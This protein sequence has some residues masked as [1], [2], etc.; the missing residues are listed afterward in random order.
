[1]KN[2]I[3]GLTDAHFSQTPSLPTVQLRAAPLPGVLKYV[4]VHLYLVVS[5]GEQPWQRWEVWQWRDALRQPSLP[6]QIAY[7]HV[8][9]NLLEPLQEIGGGPSYGIQSWQGA[10][11]EKIILALKNHGA[12]YMSRDIY[13]I[14]PGPNSNTYIARI[15]AYAGVKAVLPGTAIGKDWDGIFRLT[16]SLAP[17]SFV[18]YTP[19]LGAKL[20]WLETLELQFLGAT[21]GF[22]FQHRI[23]KHP[24]GWGLWQSRLS[25]LGIQ[26]DGR[27]QEAEG[28]H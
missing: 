12:T 11:A 16:F 26:A 27:Q 7:G 24:F 4:S 28:K 20:A 9:C 3:N 8:H 21:L 19:I 10:A 15:L 5:D 13:W 1:M 2:T 18:F 6:T 17:F 22:D 25:K 14:W 23:L